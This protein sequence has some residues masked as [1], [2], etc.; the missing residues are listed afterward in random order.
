MHNKP[1]RALAVCAWG[2]HDPSYPPPPAFPS[3]S[4]LRSQVLATRKQNF[5]FGTTV[6]SFYLFCF[7]LFVVLFCFVLFFLC[8]VHFCVLQPRVHS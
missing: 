1:G 8:E 3:P 4:G 5:L 6:P 7:V 2:R